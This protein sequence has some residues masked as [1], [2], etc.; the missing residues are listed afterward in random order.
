VSTKRIPIHRPIRAQIPPEALNLFRKMKTLKCT[1]RPIDWEGK[2]WDRDECPGC[3][4]WWNLH[5]R[6]AQLLPGIRPWHWPVIQSP[7]AEC[8]YP[9]GSQAAAAWKPNEEAQARWRVLDA[10]LTEFEQAKVIFAGSKKSARAGTQKRSVANR[11]A[12]TSG[13]R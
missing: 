9:E 5:S 1:C 10:A 8:P 3:K 2:Y 7:H 13:A 12:S 11:S 4:R 6:L